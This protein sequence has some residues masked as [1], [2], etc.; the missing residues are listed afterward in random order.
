M[1]EHCPKQILKKTTGN[2]KI[3]SPESHMSSSG[4]SWKHT[5]VFF[6]VFTLILSL[7]PPG[8]DWTLALFRD[9]TRPAV[10]FGTALP[11]ISVCVD[12]VLVFQ[13]KFQQCI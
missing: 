7:S 11:S 9:G 5:R 3:F 4:E 8:I 6:V 12:L 2:H 1:H 13:E 10:Q